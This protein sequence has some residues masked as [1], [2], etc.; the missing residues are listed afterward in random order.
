LKRIK[1]RQEVM[2]IDLL[3]SGLDGVLFDTEAAHMESSNHAFAQCGS[4]KNAARMNPSF[5]GS[6]AVAWA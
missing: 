3:V 1:G 6:T 5:A 2:A 4:D